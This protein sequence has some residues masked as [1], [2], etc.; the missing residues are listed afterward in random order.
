MKTTLTKQALKLNFRFKVLHT[1]HVYFAVIKIL[2]G[3]FFYSFIAFK[4][5]SVDTVL[6]IKNAN[7]F[8]FA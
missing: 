1:E 6:R 4:P 7:V 3:F 5:I 2:I 8:F